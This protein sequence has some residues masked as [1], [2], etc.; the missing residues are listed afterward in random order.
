MKGWRMAKIDFKD[1]ARQLA[2]ANDHRFMEPVIEKELLHYEI[3]RVM[4]DNGLLDG[5]AFQ[6]GTCLRLCYGASRYSEDLDFAGGPDFSADRLQDLKSCLEE[7]LP[8]EYLIKV[9]VTNPSSDAALVRKWRIRIDT[10]PEHPDFP[11]QKISL[12]VAAVRAYTSVPRMLQLNYEGLPASYAD[13]IVRCES[14]TEIMADKLESFICSSHVRYRDVWDLFWL[15]RRPGVDVQAAKELRASKAVDYDEV[16]RYADR[17]PA[18]LE[19]LPEIIEGS[20][21]RE[22]LRRFLPLGV[23]ERTAE[24]SDFRMLMLEGIRE[25]Y[26]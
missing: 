22:Q 6:G 24:R 4:A 25:L 8:K 23:F 2:L 1:Y 15:K 3:L 11:K 7:T 5:L 17:L 20:E 18:V 21:L 10:A 14:E 9:E 26:A 12:E 16:G 19:M 13:V